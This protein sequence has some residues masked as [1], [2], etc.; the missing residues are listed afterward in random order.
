MN[1]TPRI[2]I[3]EVINTRASFHRFYVELRMG[4]QFG[5][6]W[7][8]HLDTHEARRHGNSLRQWIMVHTYEKL[9]IQKRT[10]MHRLIARVHRVPVR[11]VYH[12]EHAALYPN[13]GA[14][15]K[16]IVSKW[17]R[18]RALDAGEEFWL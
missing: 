4:L 14:F 7:A 16:D 5:E 15:F 8:R 1:I 2:D 9:G 13:R 18:Q 6:Y 17:H 11:A 10:I 3:D 12:T